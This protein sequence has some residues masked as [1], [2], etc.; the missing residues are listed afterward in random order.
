MSVF[1]L[2]QTHD[3]SP[4]RFD[5]FQEQIFESGAFA[6]VT[7]RTVDFQ[8]LQLFVMVEMAL[9][10]EIVRVR[11]SKAALHDFAGRS[12]MTEYLPG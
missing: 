4:Q 8:Q 10:G 9:V 2:P 5:V 3:F 7:D 11:L 6:R 12:R 1:K